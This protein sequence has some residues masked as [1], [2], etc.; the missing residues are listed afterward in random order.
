MILLV[1]WRIGVAFQF[2]GA[3]ANMY[4][5]H[6]SG[7][8]LVATLLRAC[9]ARELSWYLSVLPKLSLAVGVVS[10]DCVSVT[11]APLIAPGVIS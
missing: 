2:H 9:V 10:T 11:A 8:V 6:Y 1:A 5:S 3:S 4:R 7:L